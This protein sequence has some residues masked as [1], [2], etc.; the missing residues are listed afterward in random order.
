MDGQGACGLER[1]CPK[2][3]TWDCSEWSNLNPDQRASWGPWFV[4]LLKWLL[5]G[6]N[7]KHGIMARSAR[8]DDRIIR[9]QAGWMKEEVVADGVCVL[10]GGGACTCE[11]VPKTQALAA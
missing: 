9:L 8:H 11:P 1:S 6:L 10:E 7:T 4:A 5:S 3:P 2:L